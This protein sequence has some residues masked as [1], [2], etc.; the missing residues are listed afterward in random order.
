M[1]PQRRVVFLADVDDTLVE[2][3][4]IRGDIQRHLEREYCPRLG[5][6]TGQFGQSHSPRWATRTTWARCSATG[7]NTLTGHT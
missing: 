2:N 1:T 6:A 5:N 3:D 4:R 7:S